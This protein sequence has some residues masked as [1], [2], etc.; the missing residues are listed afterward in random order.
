MNF[1]KLLIDISECDEET[2][3]LYIQK[4][5]IHNENLTEHSDSG[6]D[7]FC[8]TDKKINCRSNSNMIDL[9]VKCKLLNP[10]DTP[11][12]F[13]LYP[14]SSL[15]SKSTLRLSNSV[16]IIDSGYRGNL[17]ACVDNIGYCDYSI[18]KFN[19]YFQIITPLL[20]PMRVELVYDFD[21]TK[22]NLGGFG[23]TGL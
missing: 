12:G 18:K 11:S 15:G 6:F 4:I 21:K 8:V 2:Q 13:Y 5:D 19:K 1:Y 9:K 23:S 7:L 3:H 10:N 17:I 20:L 16:G 14:R 22:R